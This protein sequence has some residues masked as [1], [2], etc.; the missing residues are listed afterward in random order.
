MKMTNSITKLPTNGLFTAVVLLAFVAGGAGAAKGDILVNGLLDA[1]S[2]SSQVL[3]TPTGWVVDAFKTVSGPFND[4]ASSEDFANVQ[5][6]GGKGLF[7]KPFQGVIDNPITV[8]L[9]QDTPG[10]PGTKYTLTAFAG[11]EPNYSGLAAGTTTKSQLALDFLASNNA[12]IGQSVLDLAAAGL[13]TGSLPLG[14]AEY[15]VT[16]TAPAGTVTVRARGSMIDAYGTSGQQGFVMDA[17]ELSSVP[18][19][20][21]FTFLGLGV[22]GLT[23]MRR[24]R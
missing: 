4:G 14:Y 11:A 5:A 12:V 18:E 3:A 22:V 8:N 6:P 21:T 9:Y 10:T 20:T 17:F 19:P 24:R 13:G 23:G 2:V 7:F 15:T 16:G 1:T